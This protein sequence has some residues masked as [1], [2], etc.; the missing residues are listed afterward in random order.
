MAYSTLARRLLISAPGDVPIEDL[1]A[2]RKRTSQWNILFGRVVG[3]TVL[4]V[5]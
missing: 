4:P 1:T 2:F 5:S 3:P